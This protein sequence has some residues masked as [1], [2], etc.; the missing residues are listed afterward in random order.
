MKILSQITDTETIAEGRGIHELAN[1]RQ[2]YGEGNWKP[3]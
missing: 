2:R 3:A 1:L